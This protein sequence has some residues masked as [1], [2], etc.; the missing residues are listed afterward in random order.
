M[1]IKW[2][3]QFCRIQ[4]LIHKNQPY[5]YTL[6]TNNW[7]LKFLEILFE[8]HKYIQ[9][10]IQI[11]CQ[12]SRG[13]NLCLQKAPSYQSDSSECVDGLVSFRFD[14]HLP[15]EAVRVDGPQCHSPVTS[16][17]AVIS[18]PPQFVSVP[19]QY[20]CSSF[21]WFLIL[22]I[23]SPTSVQSPRLETQC[24]FRFFSFSSSLFFWIDL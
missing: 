7:K 23:M 18:P 15:A 10:R 1:K 8:N 13:R 14:S 12:K 24:H 22:G 19:F 5:S 20:S 9:Q 16:Q 3:P 2:V 11:T 21:F 17:T 6:I 4:K